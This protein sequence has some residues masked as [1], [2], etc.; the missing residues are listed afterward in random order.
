[1][2]TNAVGKRFWKGLVWGL[3]LVAPFWLSVGWALATS[4]YVDTASAGG[5]GTTTATT[6]AQAAFKTISA[7]QAA[8]TGDQSDNSLLFKKGGTWR[9][10]FTVGANGTAGHP[11]TIGAYGTGAKPLILGSVDLS[12]SVIWSEYVGTSP[13]VSVVDAAQNGSTTDSANR[14]YREIIAADTIA[15]D[16][17]KVRF[18]MR[19]SPSVAGI[20]DGTSI[21]EMAAND[22]FDA[23]PTRVTWSGGNSITLAAG[24]ALTVSDEIDFSYDKTKRYGAHLYTSDRNFYRYQPGSGTNSYGD[25][26]V[27]A[28]QTLTQ[29]VTYSAGD[30][31]YILKIEVYVSDLDIVNV[32]QADI[33]ADDIGNVIFNDEALIGVKKSE[34]AQLSSQGDFYYDS[35]AHILYVYSTSNPGSYYSQIEA[36]KYLSG[37]LIDGKDYITV[38]DLDIRYWAKNGVHLN[39]FTTSVDGVTI[40]R[41]QISYIGGGYES[42]T[43]REG[44]GIQVYD[45]VTN[46]A[47]KQN[48]ISQVYDGAI[49]L[50]SGA[51]VTA[52]GNVFNHNILSDS[53]YCFELG[54]IHADAAMSGNIV[55]NNACITPGDGWGHSQRADATG[56]G[57]QLWGLN[58]ADVGTAFSNNI[59]YN[60]VLYSVFRSTASW[61]G[62]SL[63]YNLFYPDG[64][65]AFRVNA[66]SY[67]FADWKTATS[68]DA[69]SISADPLFTNAP[70]DFTL[71]PTSPAIGKG[72]A[73]AGLHDTAG[74]TDYYGNSLPAATSGTVPTIGAEAFQAVKWVYG[75]DDGV[76]VAE[77]DCGNTDITGVVV[78]GTATDP[79]IYHLTLVGCDRAGITA[80]VATDVKN[81]V[82]WNDTATVPSISAA[83]GVELTGSNNAFSGTFGGAGTDS[84]TATTYEIADPFA[85]YGTGDYY[86]ARNSILVDAGV[87]IAGI[88]LDLNGATIAGNGYPDA[89]T[90]TY[91]VDEATGVTRKP[92]LT[93]DAFAITGVPDIGAYERLGS[94]HTGSEWEICASGNGWASNIVDSGDDAANLES[95]AVGSILGSRTAYDLRVRYRTDAGWSDWST[96]VDFL[97]GGGGRG[98]GRG[99]MGMGMH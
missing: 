67:T 81:T 99:G 40:Q 7:A 57:F 53:E 17:T 43:T 31:R 42:G 30:S 77:I 68:Q 69:N 14:N 13:W 95:Y 11:F 59:V 64:A 97:T 24:S 78:L 62:V 19:A 51:A 34:L 2:Q 94:T 47:I 26:G 16:G 83:T 80:F 91:P 32:W 39:G 41:N 1:M 58:P 87:A 38:Q 15:Y 22:D 93:A 29:S 50:Q 20:I 92:T 52:T 37:V 82:V 48:V 8:V 65:N 70:T 90:V 56:N 74:Q 28:D 72:V 63:D 10:Q 73:V 12:S 98:S 49:T 61:P 84:M 96:T 18:T 23:A 46:A 27:Q 4:Y 45:N 79:T 66:T 9:E 55:A 71:L 35:T 21:G 75:V 33:T 86:P 85:S 36:A 3:I 88:T 76:A 89:P 25:G 44:N 5:D 60:P 54:S 6:G